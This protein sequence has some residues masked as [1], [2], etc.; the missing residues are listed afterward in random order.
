MFHNARNKPQ[1]VFGQFNQTQPL[2]PIG[3]G[4]GLDGC[5]FSRTSV[6]GKQ[7]ICSIF[8]VQQGFG[9][10]DDNIPFLFVADHVV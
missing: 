6:A 2:F 1:L 3:I 5:R 7:Y 8:A 4:N 10:V 9:V